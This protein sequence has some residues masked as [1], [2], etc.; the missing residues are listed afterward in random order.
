[1]TLQEDFGPLQKI[2]DKQPLEYKISVK[3]AGCAIWVVVGV[4]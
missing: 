4:D 1:M 3:L 2:K